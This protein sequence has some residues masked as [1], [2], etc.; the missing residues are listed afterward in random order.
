[1]QKKHFTLIELLVVIAIIA[2]LA[3]MLLP[4][5]N[6]AR[7]AAR[8]TS[9]LSNKKQFSLAQTLYADDYNGFWVDKALV[10]WHALLSGNTAYIPTA[11]VGWDV[12]T[13]PADSV[14]KK[15][16]ANWTNSAGKNLLTVG[17]YGIWRPQGQFFAQE[18]KCGSIY[19]TDGASY[20]VVNFAGFIPDK[21]KAGANTIIASDSGYPGWGDGGGYYTDFTHNASDRPTIRESHEDQTTIVCLDGHCTANKAK[22]LRD[23]ANA[24]THY[25]NSAKT[26]VRF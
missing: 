18:A 20:S 5:L 17:T 6:K 24:P 11:Y 23:A 25:L 14:P 22:E 10:E 2:I 19:K 8:R 21:A 9:C 4:A 1:M 3:G 12:F 13:C 7:S 15:Y 16:D 26:F